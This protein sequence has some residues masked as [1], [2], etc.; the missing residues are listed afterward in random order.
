MESPH[1]YQGE[2]MA[3][4][5]LGGCRRCHRTARLNVPDPNGYCDRCISL[6]P[7]GDYDLESD[8]LC[9]VVLLVIALVQ[10]LKDLQP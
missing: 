4:A 6:P 2:A 9:V 5:H 10:L 3:I 7:A 8:W 1:P